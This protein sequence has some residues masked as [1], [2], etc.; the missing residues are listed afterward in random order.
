MPPKR[1]ITDDNSNKSIISI[2]VKTKDKNG[3]W[4]EY[5]KYKEQEENV[6][7]G[8][9]GNVFIVCKKNDCNYVVKVQELKNL[10]RK[11]IYEK[12]VYFLKHLQ[13]QKNF[14]VPK[15]DSFWICK[16]K[17]SRISHGFIV[18]DK[19][20]GNILELMRTH[21]TENELIIPSNCYDEM[22]KCITE[23]NKLKII[24]GDIHFK[25]FLFKEDELDKSKY[26]ICLTDFGSSGDFKITFPD[27]G[28]RGKYGGKPPLEF[29]KKYDLW[30]FDEIFIHTTSRNNKPIYYYHT[31]DIK[32]KILWTNTD[33]IT[34]RDREDYRKK[35]Y[36][37]DQK[38]YKNF[39]KETYKNFESIIKNIK[40]DNN[41][42]KNDE[43][44]AVFLLDDNDDTEED[45]LPEMVVDSYDDKCLKQ[46][47]KDGIF[48]QNSFYSIIDVHSESED[49]NPI[50]DAEKAFKIISHSN[51][52][53]KIYYLQDDKQK[54]KFK[55]NLYYLL[56][57]NPSNMTPKVI[58]YWLCT[59][60]NPKNNEFNYQGY[61]V[62]YEYISHNV[63]V[64]LNKEDNSSDKIQDNILA[65]KK[66]NIPIDMFHNITKCIN[67]LDIKKIVNPNLT[68]ENFGY[69]VNHNESY[70]PEK[71]PTYTV[72]LLDFEDAF[73]FNHY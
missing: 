19:W 10:A 66:L 2:P 40:K 42:T 23:L 73:G 54:E 24:H 14:S 6:G 59:L 58:D 46:W 61:I 48:E 34:E 28:W 43:N 16:P 3:C 25:Q 45:W 68:L 51:N 70:E 63:W 44:N 7:K 26:Q 52:K 20:Q 60:K 17:G 33:G 55:R 50:S 9:Y 49:K 31:N 56:L 36:A 21:S 47:K 11:N 64:F 12:D 67:K 27:A 29:D 18:M 71:A 72:F 65:R 37:S 4:Q 1:I 8:G 41:V 13:E 15:L 53:M 35:Y 32:N 5:I 57:L 39:E 30:V 69:F 38:T 22:I 62:F